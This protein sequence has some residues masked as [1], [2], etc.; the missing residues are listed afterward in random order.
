[1]KIALLDLTEHPEPLLAGLPRVAAQIITWLAPALPE[2]TFIAH[3]VANDNAPLPDPADFDGL[4][5][6]GSERGVYDPIPWITPLRGL[7][8]ATRAARKPIFG[9]CF[10]HQIMA[11]TF[12]GKAEKSDAGEHVGARRFT[13]GDTA[14]D[15]HVLH[16]DQV[17]EIPPGATVTASAPYCPVAALDYDF[18]AASVQFHP[19]YTETQLR[20]L[21]DRFRDDLVPAEIC[22][23]AIASL[24]DTDV[25]IDLH[26]RKT[27][28]FF[29]QHVP[30]GHP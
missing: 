24:Q 22:D 3:D 4:L 27:A 19:E 13:C 18:P 20:A 14:I 2:A 28:A 15:A 11:D 16:K 12:G 10:G 26:A 30:Q 25:K 1:M 29:R 17:T 7:L 6:S 21:W 8:A 23:A 5:L 9:I